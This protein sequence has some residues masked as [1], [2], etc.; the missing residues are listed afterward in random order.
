MTNQPSDPIVPYEGVVARRVGSYADQALEPID[1]GEIA[2]NVVRGAAHGRVRP[3]RLLR[4]GAP[5]RWLGVLAAAGLVAVVA[6]GAII[7]IGGRGLTSPSPAA[8][9][10]L[11]GAT[12]TA[13][14][15]GNV[16]GACAI[17]SLDAHI[18]RWDGAAGS[19]IATVVL[20][21]VGASG[22]SLPT[23]GE[24]ALV[25]ATG[26]VL[27]DG[28][29][30]GSSDTIALAPN[31]VASTLVEASNYCGDPAT[32]PVTV[33]IK[34]ADGSLLRA[35]PAGGQSESDGLPPCNGAAG[36]GSIQMQ[37]FKAGPPS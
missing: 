37:P 11:P 24:P 20:Q 25:D 30:D 22:C 8:S 18:V 32:Q 34:F 1:A 27:I 26:R 14:P 10:A 7:G 33:W 17:A 35:K 31:D 5:A 13:V 23:L 16:A 12:P 28:R 36:S 3:A 29:L 21:N 19:R 9:Q 2:R 4:S 6:V 15:N